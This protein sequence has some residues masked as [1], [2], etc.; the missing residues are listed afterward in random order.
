[1]TR[2]PKPPGRRPPKSR[3][4]T[5]RLPPAVFAAAAVGLILFYGTALAQ[6]GGAAATAPA[7][8]PAAVGA[9]LE[10]AAGNP[11]PKQTLWE[12]F[13]AGG[14]AMWAL[15]ACSV[16]ALAIIIE[17]LVSLRRS[18]TVPAGFMPGLLGVYRDPVEDRQQ[19][20]AHARASDSAIARIVTAGLN[21]LPRGPVAA[22]KAMEDAGANEALKLRRN[23]RMLYAIGSVSTLLGLIGTI[24]GMIKAFQVA[25]GGGMGKAELLAK[26]IYE[27]MVCTFGGLAVAI[28][29][30]A[31]YYW[32]LGRIERL[33][34][35]MNDALA[36]FGD[37]IAAAPTPRQS[38]SGLED[39]E[40][41]VR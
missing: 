15:L 10:G 14:P 7:T 13:Q 4:A 11:A 1:M 38:A 20:L 41:T 36:D 6:T 34:G 26:G 23:V 5:W 33:V 9:A 32:F 29:C 28:V 22:E 27:A 25:S 30:T 24:S 17:R 16:I 3:L 40:M 35:D 31:F 39:V 21:R 8:A 12:L 2:S 37:R 19:A 18:Y